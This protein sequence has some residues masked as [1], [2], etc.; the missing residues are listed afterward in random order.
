[1]SSEANEELEIREAHERRAPAG[2]VVYEAIRLEGESELSRR[3][4]PLAWSGLAA[5]LSMGFSFLGQALLQHHLPQTEWRLLVA[6]LGYTL[7]FLVVILARQ[8][9]FTENTLTVV[10]PFLDRRT[11]SRLLNLGRV[12]TIVFLANMAGAFLFA[13]TLAKSDVVEPSMHHTLAEIGR[14]AIAYEPGAIFVRAIFAGW[15]IAL[16]AWMLPYAKS[17]RVLV[18]FVLT[19][20]IG[21]AHLSH[22]IA[23]AVEGL[24]LVV[25]GEVGLATFLG[26]FV[27][28]ALLGN[29]VGGVVLVS[30]LHHVQFASERARERV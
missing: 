28:P 27:A 3:N 29:I 30:I 5:G 17:S 13:L 20:F 6:K 12:W 14:T 18:I 25:T 11:P 1:M 7:G 24:Y 21:V 16:M 26:R 9:L 4:A 8:Q 10:L 2:A 22:I 19:Y 23:G 15:I